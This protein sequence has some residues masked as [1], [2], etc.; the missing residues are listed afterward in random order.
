MEQ[1]TG[2]DDGPEL[3]AHVIRAYKK[4]RAV[5]LRREGKTLR[6]IGEYVHV[7]HECVRAWTAGVSA[8]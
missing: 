6:E 5:E 3:P 4:Q 1:M 2:L 8:K 7:S